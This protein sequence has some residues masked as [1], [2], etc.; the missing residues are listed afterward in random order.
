[1]K[2]LIGLALVAMVL[3]LGCSLRPS[4]VEIE[5]NDVGQVRMPEEVKKAQQGQATILGGWT[6]SNGS[7]VNVVFDEEGVY[8]ATLANGSNETGKWEMRG[9][10]LMLTPNSDLDFSYEFKVQ[11]LTGDQAEMLV[12]DVIQVWTRNK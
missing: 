5:K 1:M 4:A 2:K 11:T 12:D 9:D 10:D 6:I 8:Y 3:V 7:F